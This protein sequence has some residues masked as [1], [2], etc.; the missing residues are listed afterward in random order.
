VNFVGT[1]K[2]PALDPAVYRAYEKDPE[3]VG[4]LGSRN[5]QPT[6]KTKKQKKKRRPIQKER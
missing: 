1:E 4:L 3:K 5:R 2:H 6:K